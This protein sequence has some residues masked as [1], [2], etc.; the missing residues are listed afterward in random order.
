M[1]RSLAILVAIL[2]GSASAGTETG[3]ILFGHGQYGSTETS[4]GF[5]F[6]FLEGG[7]KIDNPA[8]STA[9]GGQRWVFDNDWPAAKYQIATLLAA[10]AAGKRVTVVGSGTCLVWGDS[11]TAIDIKIVD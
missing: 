4:A 7:N 2:C 1:K 6:F 11:E 8:C 3:T 10:F 9:S 5:T